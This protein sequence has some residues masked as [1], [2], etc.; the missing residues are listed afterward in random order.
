MRR[1]GH[2]EKCGRT[3]LDVR[4]THREVPCCSDWM[5]GSPM[6]SPLAP[7]KRSPHQRQVRCCLDSPPSPGVS[8]PRLRLPHLGALW[9]K[10]PC[11]TPSADHRCLPPELP[12]SPTQVLASPGCAVGDPGPQITLIHASVPLTNLSQLP[13][14]AGVWWWSGG[15][16]CNPQDQLSP[17]LGA[18]LVTLI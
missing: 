14:A 13:P 10:R 7:H 8:C 3:A 4:V 15:C 1:T 18:L 11:L 6:P 9:D 5:P 17:H 12:P 16:L 2:R